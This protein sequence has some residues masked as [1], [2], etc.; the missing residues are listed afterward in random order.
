MGKHLSGK[1]DQGDRD[2]V[3]GKELIAGSDILRE[4]FNNVDVEVPLWQSE[5]RDK[6]LCREFAFSHTFFKLSH[7]FLQLVCLYFSSMV[8]Y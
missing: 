7:L 5:S 4:C 2:C 8:Y 1:W 3:H 6:S